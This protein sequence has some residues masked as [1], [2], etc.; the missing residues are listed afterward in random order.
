MLAQT[1]RRA[2]S[3]LPG[4]RA[5]RLAALPRPDSLLLPLDLPKAALQ[6]GARAAKPSAQQP[7]LVRGLQ[8]VAELALLPAAALQAEQPARSAWPQPSWGPT[9]ASPPALEP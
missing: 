1:P 8:P 9:F 3:R 6:P 5:E 2:L 4:L 7:A